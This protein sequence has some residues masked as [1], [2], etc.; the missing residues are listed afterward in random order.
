MKEEGRRGEKKMR[1][2]QL[3]KE[4]ILMHSYVSDSMKSSELW[5][6]RKASQHSGGREGRKNFSSFVEGRGGRQKEEAL[7]VASGGRRAE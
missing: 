3:G 2:E 1:A 7:Y 5:W 6:R 4:A